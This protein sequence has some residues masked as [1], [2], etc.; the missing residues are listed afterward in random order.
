LLNINIF[1]YILLTPLL[2][3]NIL[4]KDY[5]INLFQKRRMIYLSITLISTIVIYI[6]SY[7]S[8]KSSYK[9]SYG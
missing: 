5:S 4:L 6:L 8:L 3:G 2:S 7:L 9:R 1:D